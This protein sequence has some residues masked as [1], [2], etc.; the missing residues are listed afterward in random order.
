MKT[1]PVNR[2]LLLAK[3]VRVRF[4]ISLAFFVCRESLR[5]QLGWLPG[6]IET[7][8]PQHLVRI[9]RMEATPNPKDHPAGN[10]G[11][12]DALRVQAAA[13]A[14]QQAAL[15]EEESRL[16]KRRVAL[17]QQEAQLAAH[18]NE[19]HRRLVEIRD[20]TRQ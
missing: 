12:K 6:T 14:A 19:K 1:A 4:P 20:Q 10:P 7:N 3:K 5:S 11:I 9:P 2:V 16:E 17:E 15:T 8:G 18:L 13:V